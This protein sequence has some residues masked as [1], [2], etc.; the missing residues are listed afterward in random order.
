MDPIRYGKYW[1][2]DKV[3]TGGMAEIYKAIAVGLDGKQYTLAIKRILPQFSN[4]E[5]FVSLL[6][7]E[8]KIMVLLN[9]PNLVPIVEFGKVEDSYFI[10]MDY[11]DGTTLKALF[12]RVRTRQ[13]QFTVDMAVHVVREIGIG[14]AYAHRKTDAQGKPLDIVHRDISPANVLISFE[15]DIKITDFGISKAANQSHRTQVGIIRGKTGYMSPEQTRAN[16]TIDQRS[17]IYSLGII[18]FELLTGERLYKAD[19]VP[20]ALR[21]IREGKIPGVH[22][23]RPEVPEELE[24][25]LMKALSQDSET[26][27]QTAQEFV[28][29]LN[30]FLSR[31]SPRGRPVRITHADVVGFLSRY[32][33]SELS[34]R[35]SGARVGV[36]LP[37]TAPSEQATIIQPSEE[38]T[39][40]QTFAA[41]PLYELSEA[42]VEMESQPEVSRPVTISSTPAEK[43][44]ISNQYFVKVGWSRFVGIAAEGR[45]AF[46]KW[47]RLL[48]FGSMGAVALTLLLGLTNLRQCKNDPET[49]PALVTPSAPSVPEKVVQREGRA[50]IRIRSRPPGAKVSLDGKV[51]KGKT[52]LVLPPLPI[53]QKVKLVLTLQGY[54]SYATTLEPK[55]TKE[56]EAFIFKLEKDRS[57]PSPKPTPAVNLPPL[58]TGQAPSFL[59]VL[60]RPAGGK[61]F[62]DR[63]E[64][65]ELFSE[66][67]QPGKHILQFKL[68]RE[69]SGPVVFTI[70][71]GQ[72]L[73]CIYDF[74]TREYPC[75]E[76]K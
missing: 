64:R 53:G 32:F 65:S 16:H 30:E 38:K 29:A 24:A 74:A 1:L 39:K 73:S 41:N 46:A 33:P 5:E 49:R 58:G 51:L 76:V 9:H 2:V 17:D 4:D 54:R 48:Q 14:L 37:E 11:V 8:A 57:R 59:S 40:I 6:V 42:K 36:V 10:A 12:R 62:L 13:E 56:Q 26:R 28:D 22:D 55:Q 23:L 45:S 50:V 47:P 18:L 34:A 52:P 68:E 60:T 61:I 19:S 35:A 75:R 20:E 44:T 72:K 21:M 66:K 15:G 25:I 63:R 7:D 69:D 70:Q 43:T 3:A 67:I 31:W 27:Y 71:P